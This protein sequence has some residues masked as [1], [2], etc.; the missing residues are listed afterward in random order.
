MT[1]NMN[2]D[3]V[4]LVSLDHMLS[5]NI[6]WA[7]ASKAMVQA[8]LLRQNP[9][10]VPG[11]DAA[12]TDATVVAAPLRKV[13]SK[14]LKLQTRR[15]KAAIRAEGIALGIPTELLDAPHMLNGRKRPSEQ[16]C[17][18]SENLIKA[19]KA[20]KVLEPVLDVAQFCAAQ[21]A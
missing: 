20:R 10:K 18:K 15:S 9:I 12:A 5:E 1:Q 14:S 2:P 11:L 6:R 16:G 13:S 4:L 7:T 17:A 21:G 19:V 3:T 8:M